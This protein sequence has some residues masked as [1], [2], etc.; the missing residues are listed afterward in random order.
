MYSYANIDRD[1]RVVRVIISVIYFQDDTTDVSMAGLVV[2]VS[3]SVPHLYS[4]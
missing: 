4:G 2:L 3:S 1:S